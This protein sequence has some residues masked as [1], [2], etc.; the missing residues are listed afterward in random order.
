MSQI[1]GLMSVSFGSVGALRQMES[2]QNTKVNG[3]LIDVEFT[4]TADYLAGDRFAVFKNMFIDLNLRKGGSG[5]GSGGSELL[6]DSVPVY[7]LLQYSDMIAGVSVTDTPMTAGEKY[8]ISGYVDLGFFPLGE[9]DSLDCEVYCSSRPTVDVDVTLSTVFTRDMLSIIKKYQTAKP[10]GSDQSYSNVVGVYLDTK[11]K[12]SKSVTI[13]D[14]T[15]DNT[16][17]N[18]EDAIAYTNAVA[19]FEVF[20]RFGELWVDPY[21]L[22]Q[23]LTIKCPTDNADTEIL[24]VGYV[25]NTAFLSAS[26]G[27]WEA[28]KNLLMTKI[29]NAGG[30]K[31]DYLRALGLL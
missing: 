13:R 3:F 12:L 22:S 7:Q 27:A 11:D 30:E 20:T 9:R 31:V 5:A 16:T 28:N 23:N 17:V 25:F 4:P 2:Q 6:I 29:E 18:V 24:L 14:Q 10:T 8:R 1:N 26:A 15:N 19:R 21:G